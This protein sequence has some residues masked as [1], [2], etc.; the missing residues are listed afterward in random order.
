M[1]RNLLSVI[2]YPPTPRGPSDRRRGDRPGRGDRQRGAGA[3]SPPS[4]PPHSIPSS[5]TERL[6]NCWTCKNAYRCRRSS[7]SLLSNPGLRE[8]RQELRWVLA[9]A[10]P[11]QRPKSSSASSGQ[12]RFRFFAALKQTHP[13]LVSGGSFCRLPPAKVD[14]VTLPLLVG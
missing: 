4:Q 6:R 12:P 7:C 11:K 5:V 3:I 13:L 14:K 9:E 10:A 8:R 1:R 2:D